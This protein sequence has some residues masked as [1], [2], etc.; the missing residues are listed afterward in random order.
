MPTIANPGRVGDHARREAHPG[1]A[2]SLKLRIRLATRRA[3]LTRRLAD[4]AAKTETPE[5]ALYASRLTS[6]RR[7]RQMA[8]SL[9]RV[10]T[11][12]REPAFTRPP[13]SIV[14]RYAVLEAG[15]AIQL[16]IARLASP[17]PVTAKGMAML[18]RIF[19]DGLSSA[20]Y[21]PAEPG[22]LR[23]QLLVARAELDPGPLGQ[24]RRL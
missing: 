16:T 14:N 24:T 6:D 11:E 23:R 21:N 4:G 9:R 3:S 10:I 20:M 15:E 13:V 22:T 17:E 5:L 18:E 2:E 7:R 12:A 8:R 19:S 1:R